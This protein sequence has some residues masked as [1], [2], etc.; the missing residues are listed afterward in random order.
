MDRVLLVEDNQNLSDAIKVYFERSGFEVCQAFDGQQGLDLFQS[1]PFDLVI[2]DIMLPILDGW[3]LLEHM[4]RKQR[5]PIIVLTARGQEKDRLHGYELG[6]DDYVP[7][8]F[9]LRELLAKS[10]AILRRLRGSED[11]NEQFFDG[12]FCMDWRAHRLQ[13]D[14]KELDLSPRELDLMLLLLSRP[15]TVF[16]REEL[17]DLVWGNRDI[18]DFRTVDTHIKQIRAKLGEKRY[19]IQ[20]VWGVGYRFETPG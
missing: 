12:G 9:S 14:G 7:K 11:P 17:L 10:R 3:E 20:T 18:N 19:L 8:P 1:Q 5:I 6:A 2:L 16:R 13:L 4:H 15:R